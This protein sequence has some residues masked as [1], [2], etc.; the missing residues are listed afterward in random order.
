MDEKE[1]KRSPSPV[2]KAERAKSAGNLQNQQRRESS[3]RTETKSAA[4]GR[5]SR[6]N[7]EALTGRIS[8]EDRERRKVRSTGESVERQRPKRR[9]QT[10]EDSSE[11]LRKRTRTSDE[12]AA[13]PKKGL[14]SSN[15]NIRRQGAKKRPQISEEETE[16]PRKQT[17]ISE[18]E[19]ERPR[20]RT[21]AAQEAQ[22]QKKQ[23]R[24]TSGKS[25]M[26]R[27]RKKR[28]GLLITLL[29]LLVIAAIAG[30]FLW[31]KYSPSKE[32]IDAKKY[33]GI[34]KD[35][36]MA[37]TVDDQIV[38]P[39]GIISDGKA[40]VQY[41]IVRDY[42]NS[43]FYWDSNENELLYTL[44]TDIVTVKADSKDYSIS[45]EK[46]SEDYVILKTDGSTAYIAL[47]FIQQ[48][49]NIDYEVYDS[50]NRVMITCDW[51]KKR[52]ATVKSD[53]QVRYRGGV[54]SPIVTDVK[55]K[56]EIIV[57]ENEQN[58]K[59][60]LTKDGYIG[61]VKK[62]ALKNEKTKNVTRDFVQPEYT[63]IKKDYIINM[64]WH[65]V[66]NS[67][68]NSG[69]QQRLA[70]SKGLTTIVPTWFHVKDVQ[71]NL[72]SIASADYVNY[73][74]QAGLE[75]WAAI[76]DFDG[77]IGSNDE[78][79]QLL[80]QSSSRENL[81]N[82]LMGAVA[83]VGIDGI[84]VDFEKISKDCG[85]HYIQFIREL[86][87]KCRQN[88]IVLSVDNYVPKGY[89]RQYN[90]KEQG[91]MADYVII[92]GYDEH[93]GSSLEAG[94]VS[95]YDF[96][97]EGIEE[98]IKEVPAEKVISGI[99]FFTRLW[100]ETPKTQEEL[101]Q[102][103]GTEAADY[104]MKVTSEAMGMSTAREKISQ[105][106]AE[107]TLDEVTG[108]NYATWEADGIT[109]EIWLEDATSIEPKLKL[110]KE[111][112]LAGTAAWALGQ[113]SSDIW[114]LIAQYVK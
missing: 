107:T 17:R 60:V 103:A 102:E 26:K 76:R 65:N 57:L 91:V 112:N 87:V 82:Q 47:D 101:N 41:E 33:Y 56:D 9:M 74:H 99:P 2:K 34:E 68:A 95:S 43:R 63:S 86:S 16:R 6:K 37:I 3:G 4:K 52:I 97:K 114:D 48:Y 18:E 31:K 36:Q 25:H 24:P 67:T 75:V 98:T 44:P 55:K 72:E 79:L 38:G 100:T 39:H 15:E 58:W 73:A 90:R 1:I 88:G 85:E 7:T 66:T 109:Y 93:N 5:V 104:P 62:N 106:G 78:S 71:G 20:K 59:K 42:I 23:K 11:K 54:K 113:E 77:G 27:K 53:T 94:A 22:Y 61:Y 35:D 21:R 64:A 51:G 8:L 92:M 40:Y 110:M 96:V 84:N 81:I 28:V 108:D 29:I 32:R 89:N 10:S 50:P 83:Q 111:N 12:I 13:K 30:A 19:A 14:Q 45:K 105:A 69:L 70:A 46:N 80:S 49:T